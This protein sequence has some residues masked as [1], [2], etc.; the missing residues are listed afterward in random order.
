M[1]TFYQAFPVV[2]FFLILSQ[3]STWLPLFGSVS[4]LEQLLLIPF[5]LF[6][7]ILIF[8]LILSLLFLILILLKPLSIHGFTNL[9]KEK[10]KRKINLFFNAISKNMSFKKLINHQNKTLGF[11]HSTLALN[12]YLLILISLQK[13]KG[14][15]KNK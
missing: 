8:I 7:P 9:K 6:I 10:K 15:W 5:I 4:F 11:S 13:E 1:F 14:N 12:S 3:P 2:F